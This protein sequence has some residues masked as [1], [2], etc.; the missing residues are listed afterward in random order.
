M[1]PQVVQSQSGW[2]I[3]SPSKPHRSSLRWPPPLPLTH[4]SLQHAMVKKG[5]IENFQCDFQEK[6]I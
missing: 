4:R 6:H 3:H 1:I 5:V 2:I